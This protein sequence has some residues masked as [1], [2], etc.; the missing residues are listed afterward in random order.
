MASPSSEVL[1]A[2]IVSEVAVPR[3]GGHEANHVAL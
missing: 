2:V 3:L 1:G